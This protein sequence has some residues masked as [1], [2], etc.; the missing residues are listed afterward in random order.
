[1]PPVSPT[2][3]QRLQA[4]ALFK[5][6]GLSRLAE[7]VQAGVTATTISRMER[8]GEVV[9]IARGLY[10]LA[11]AELHVQQSLAEASRLVPKGVVCLASALAFHGLTDQ[12]PPQVWIAIGRKAWRPRLNYP[13]IRV[14]RF[15][16]EQLVR[17]VA[18]AQIAGTQVPVFGVAKTVADL[19]RYRRTVGD[20]I[21]IEGLREALKQRKATPAEIAHEAEAGGVWPTVEP[22]LMAL[23][24]HA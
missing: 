19:F 7:F 1:M 2:S 14:V 3:T 15:S 11:D 4:L 21:A 9:R 17:G 12:M 18:Q 8:A 23:T 22:Y 6:R 5:Q 24:S 20:L 16:A 13:P 10:Q